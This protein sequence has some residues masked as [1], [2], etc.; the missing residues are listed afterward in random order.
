MPDRPTALEL[1]EAVR[2]FLETEVAKTAADPRLRFRALV[3]AN[4]LSIASR[5]VVLDEAPASSEARI[6]HALLGDAPRRRGRPSRSQSSSPAAEVARALSAELCRRI[7]DGT[8]PAETIAAVRRIVEAKLATASPRYLQK[9]R[10][11]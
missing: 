9:T 5:E 6:L 1:L 3:A 10:P 2:L 11:T 8:A 4:A 7:R